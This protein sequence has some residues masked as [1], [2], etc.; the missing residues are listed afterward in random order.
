[1][2]GGASQGAHDVLGWWY[3]FGIELGTLALHIC[4]TLLSLVSRA[5]PW[6]LSGTRMGVRVLLVFPCASARAPA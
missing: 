2:V 3:L 5:L 4:V 1:M 6:R